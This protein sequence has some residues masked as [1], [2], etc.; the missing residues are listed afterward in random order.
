MGSGKMGIWSNG[1]IFLSIEFNDVKEKHFLLT[2]SIP[3]FYRSLA[4]A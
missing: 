1:K 4:Q 2:I 3:I